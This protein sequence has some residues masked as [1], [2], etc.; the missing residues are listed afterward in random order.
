MLVHTYY[1]VSKTDVLPD[2][3]VKPYIGYVWLNIGYVWLNIGYVWFDIGH[4]WF[5]IG[6]VW[7][8]IGYVWFIHMVC[9]VHTYGMY[10]SYI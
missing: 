4:V 8:D 10:G 1:R 5:D 2:A 3:Y 9:M 7:F 6:H